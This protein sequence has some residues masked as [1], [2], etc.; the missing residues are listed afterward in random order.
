MKKSE[1]ITE[2]LK[3]WDKFPVFVW[4]EGADLVTEVDGHVVRASTAWQMDTRLDGIAPKP[5]NLYFVDAPD[6]EE[7]DLTT[8]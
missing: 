4:Q 6:Y 8:K 7:A 2:H 1:A 3:H 5:R